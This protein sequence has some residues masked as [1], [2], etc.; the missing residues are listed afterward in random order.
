MLQN[1]EEYLPKKVNTA[2]FEIII[3]AVSFYSVVF[4]VN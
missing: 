1:I 3:C 4:I 2:H